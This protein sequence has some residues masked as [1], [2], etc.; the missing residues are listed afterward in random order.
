MGQNSKNGS[1]RSFWLKGFHKAAETAAG[2][3][4]S[5]SLTGAGKS[6]SEMAQHTAVGKRPESLA[7]CW[8][9]VLVPG[10]VGISVGLSECLHFTRA[11]DSR[12]RRNPRGNDAIPPA[13]FYVFAG[14]HMSSPH[15]RRGEFKEVYQRIRGHF[16]KPL[17]WNRRDRIKERSYWNKDLKEVK[18]ISKADTAVREDRVLAKGNSWRCKGKAYPACRWRRERERTIGRPL[19]GRL[20]SFPPLLAT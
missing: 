2:A 12:E 15:L 16:W 9:E 4:S 3:Q 14:S 17:Q 19:P 7:G 18:E 20:Q 8:Q 1:A 11:S 10:H 6:A 5:A 13:I